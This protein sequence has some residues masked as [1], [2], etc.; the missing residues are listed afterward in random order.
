MMSPYHAADWFKSLA[1]TTNSCRS[2]CTT[3]EGPR[4]R[5]TWFWASSAR[6]SCHATTPLAVVAK[7]DD[8][9][10]IEKG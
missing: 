7:E 4:V 9:I 3:L 10:Y 6:N 8:T 2:C 1:S 5:C